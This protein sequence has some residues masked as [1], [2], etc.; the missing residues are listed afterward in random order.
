MKFVR[1]G[2]RR[3][4]EPKIVGTGEACQILG[5]RPQNIGQIKGLP[6]PYDHIRATTLYRKDELEEFAKERNIRL[7]KVVQAA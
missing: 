3:E 2:P 4:A 5:C 1:K 6:D 7:G